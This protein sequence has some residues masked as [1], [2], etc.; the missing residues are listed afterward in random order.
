MSYDALTSDSDEDYVF[1]VDGLVR[2]AADGLRRAQGWEEKRQVV[3]EYVERAYAA[4]LASQELTDFFCVS[5]GCVIDQLEL[6]ESEADAVAALFDEAHDDFAS[7]RKQQI[8]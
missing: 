6:S 3:S 4:H 5:S 2:F 7:W 1:F 8:D